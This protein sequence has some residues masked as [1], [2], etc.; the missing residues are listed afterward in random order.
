MNYYFLSQ[1]KLIIIFDCFTFTS[2]MNLIQG[3][4]LY[5]Y[6]DLDLPSYMIEHIIIVDSFTFA[7]RMNLEMT[8][9]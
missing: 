5:Y 8:T 1:S 6:S 2:R 4:R 7:S 3:G 9:G